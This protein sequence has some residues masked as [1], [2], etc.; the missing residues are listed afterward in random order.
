MKLHINSS[1]L[2]KNRMCRIVIR[3]CNFTA[4]E[5]II[6]ANKKKKERKN[7]YRII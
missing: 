5:R 3:M 6:I 7:T 1:S 4:L 2:F